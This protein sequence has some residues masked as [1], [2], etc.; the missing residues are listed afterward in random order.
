MLVKHIMKYTEKG[1]TAER[2]QKKT[3]EPIEWIRDVMR[4]YLTHPGISVQGVLD[5]MEI[6]G[7]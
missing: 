7:R 2:I 4:M 5:R 1:W 3:G 6:R